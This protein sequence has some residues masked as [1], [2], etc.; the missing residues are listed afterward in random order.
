MQ[1]KGKLLF[2]NGSFT[3]TEFSGLFPGGLPEKP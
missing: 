1:L 3:V 2:Y